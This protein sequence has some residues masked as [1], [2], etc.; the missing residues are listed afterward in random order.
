[1][2]GHVLLTGETQSGKTH[3]GNVLH[4]EFPGVSI[5]INTNGAR[6]YGHKTQ[7]TS[8]FARAV[9]RSRKVNVL[10]PEDPVARMR[11]LDEIKDRIFRWAKAK[12]HYD[13]PWCQIIVDEAQEYS[14][15]KRIKGVP[16]A[17]RS[18]ATRGL[19]MAGVRLVAITQY[20]A[21]LNTTT[22]TNLPIRVFFDPGDEGIQFWRNKSTPHMDA[23]AEHTRQ[24]YNFAIHHKRDVRLYTKL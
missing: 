1:M 5:F 12:D 22:R 7:G 13:T 15:E 11:I 9:V 20:P 3:F 23:I 6:V 8:E 21:T 18:F 14:H 2:N 4:R 16:D 10:M 17:V 24:K 19:G